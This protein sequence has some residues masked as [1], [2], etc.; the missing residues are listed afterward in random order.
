MSTPFSKLFYFFQKHREQ[1]C[2]RYRDKLKYTFSLTDH[3]QEASTAQQSRYPFF[4]QSGQ[5][6]A[7]C[8][9]ANPAFGGHGWIC[10]NTRGTSPQ[11][12]CRPRSLFA[13]HDHVA[14]RRVLI[15]PCRHF[16]SFRAVYIERR[17]EN[18]VGYA[19]LYYIK[20]P[21]TCQYH[22]FLIFS[23]LNDLCCASIISRFL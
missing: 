4:T 6:R 19:L 5:S 21:S 13:P 12:N 23:S 8:F 17:K 18:E 10:T 16:S 1:K 11:T 2:S 9:C 22:R 15:S 20:F 14:H 7:H 3:Q